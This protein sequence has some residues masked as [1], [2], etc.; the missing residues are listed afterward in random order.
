[1]LKAIALGAKFVFVG[2]PFLYAA[3]IAG[4]AGVAHAIRILREEVQRDMGLLGINS[5]DEMTPKLLRR[6][7]GDSMTTCTP[8]SS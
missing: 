7:G 5:L 2:R 6:I 4:E 3:S 8:P 1:M